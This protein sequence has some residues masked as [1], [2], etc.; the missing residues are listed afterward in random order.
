MAMSP[1]LRV[2]LATFLVGGGA[3]SAVAQGF[4]TP[5]S[6]LP[7]EPLILIEA[8]RLGGFL[9]Q[10]LGHP[11][12]R[13]LL[14]RELKDEL[15]DNYGAD[16]D[17]LEEV[18]EAIFGAPVLELA[19]SVFRRGASAAFWVEGSEPLWTIAALGE[20]G[21]GV[22]A[23]DELLGVA[24]EQ[25]MVPDLDEVYSETEGGGLW[26]LPDFVIAHHGDLL[27]AGPSRRAALAGIERW[28]KSDG[29]GSGHRAPD[30]QRSFLEGRIDIARI[31]AF[32]EGD[33]LE[34]FARLIR[35]PGAQFLMGA[36]FT[37]MGTADVQEFSIDL[38]AEGLETRFRAGGVKP[39]DTRVLFPG[40]D[41]APALLTIPRSFASAV[42]H[43]DLAGLFEHREALFDAEHLGGFSK[44]ITDLSVFVGG[45]D[46]SETILPHISPWMR[47]VSAIPNY[48]PR[49]VPEFV[50]PGAAL[51]LRVDDPEGVG[52][53]LTAAFQSAIALV[54]IDRAQNGMSAFVLELERVG[55]ST[56]TLAHL[57]VP[58][59][60]DGIDVEHNLAPACAMVGTHFI[61]GSHEDLV[62]QLVPVLEQGSGDLPVSTR[63]H[64]LISTKVAA[65]FI[66][67]NYGLLVAQQ[68]LES[69]KSE[70]EIH[71]EFNAARLFLGVFEDIEVSIASPEPGVVEYGTRIRFA[72]RSTEEEAPK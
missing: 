11:F 26:E 72:T 58:N 61:L 22:D 65:E 27:V 39:E 48:D 16:L 7:E 66:K 30:R 35:D 45:G 3:A 47:I 21:G 49:A 36:R 59:P 43:R 13:G 25:Q 38:N 6:A 34:E 33:D 52:R 71:K 56:L 24:I 68:L 9:E 14:T 64:L 40:E 32:G 44:A 50:L 12:F 28:S 41:S 19:G 63:E 29:A 67:R 51:I 1:S 46:F 23:F 4:T 2:L 54:N 42:V 37:A 57:P 8:P 18:S 31:R 17:A 70:S 69:G 55:E 60:D 53:T 10:G 62:R 15:R 20:A 5:R